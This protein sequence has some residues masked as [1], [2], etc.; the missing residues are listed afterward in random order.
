MA[1]Q[2]WPRGALFTDHVPELQ[3]EYNEWLTGVAE[4][5][6]TLDR[7]MIFIDLLATGP[8]RPP[9]RRDRLRWKLREARLRIEYAIMALRGQWPED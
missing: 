1:G 2:V 8:S 6:E 4:Q 7:P 5:I 3:R 9:T